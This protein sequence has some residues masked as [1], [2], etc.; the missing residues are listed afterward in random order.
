MNESLN[1]E[2]T[3]LFISKLIDI[4][5]QL[6][7]P[8]LMILCLVVGSLKLKQIAITTQQPALRYV[9]HGLLSYAL[10][11]IVPILMM[12]VIFFV[13][14]DS[15][16]EGYMDLTVSSVGFTFAL[17]GTLFLFKANLKFR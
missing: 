12:P 4:G 11:F 14:G 10:S 5:I 2:L 17:I 13:A 15:A 8:F 3:N 16:D 6:V 7:F 1:L 9:S